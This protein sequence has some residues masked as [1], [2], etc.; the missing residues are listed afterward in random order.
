MVTFVKL[1]CGFFLSIFYRIEFIGKENIPEKGAAILYANHV[2]AL[3]MFC[4]GFSIRR[5]IRWMA[6][7][8]LFRIPVVGWITPRL[9]A[10]PVR[11]GKADVESIKTALHKLEE[12]HIVGI[13]P[14]GTRTKGRDDIK[15][16][17][18]RGI[19]AIAMKSEIPLIPV[20]IDASYKPFT[21]VR[22][23]FG[24]PFQLDFDKEKKYTHEE[25]TAIS[26]G[27]MKKVYSLMGD[28]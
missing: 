19:V 9:G 25:M 10:F 27:L 4:I 12:G 5:L 7:E 28:Y 15:G 24:E 14:E 1:F 26:R 22:I 18:K 23:I 21:K 20:A 3:D 2:S 8:E 17:A 11:R 6:K 13:F 16:R